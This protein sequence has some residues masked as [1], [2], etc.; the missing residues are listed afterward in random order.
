M[1]M[2]VGYDILKCNLLK[3]LKLYSYCRAASG[4]E[5]AMFCGIPTRTDIDTQRR[6]VC[7]NVFVFSCTYFHWWTGAVTLQVYIVQP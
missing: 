4:A 3:L 5:M 2:R 1:F 6:Q 7:V